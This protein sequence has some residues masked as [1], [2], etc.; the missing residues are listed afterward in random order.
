[1]LVENADALLK[2]KTC[3]YGLMEVGGKMERDHVIVMALTIINNSKI[4][5]I[6]KYERHIMYGYCGPWWLR[7]SSI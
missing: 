2:E 1:V 4:V 3:F 6:T 5:M 7:I